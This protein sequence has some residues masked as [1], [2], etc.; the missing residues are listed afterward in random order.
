MVKDR[1]R[2]GKHQPLLVFYV[3][4]DG[5]TIKANKAP[6]KT[7]IMS[8]EELIASRNNNEKEQQRRLDKKASKRKGK[9]KDRDDEDR[10][11]PGR[12]KSLKNFVSSAFK[13]DRSSKEAASGSS[14][15]KSRQRSNG[16]HVLS[17]NGH[18]SSMGVI[19]P[20]L[21]INGYVT[22]NRS[23]EVEN[24]T[25]K[26]PVNSKERAQSQTSPLSKDDES[27]FRY[28][29]P[30]K[31][32]GRSSEAHRLQKHQAHL[33]SLETSIDNYES[34]E[35]IL[36]S[37]R[38]RHRRSKSQQL[39]VEH[40]DREKESS[41]FIAVPKNTV[42]DGR[43]QTSGKIHEQEHTSKHQAQRRYIDNGGKWIIVCV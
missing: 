6:R 28:D 27:V 11:P 32:D 9:K 4:Q 42:E 21:E 37:K 3:N 43:R 25:R 7:E 38:Q 30:K 12:R 5:E 10:N 17:V 35:D 24:E 8:K 26:S 41:R 33:K 39:P 22:E 14:S 31:V 16:D 13:K 2:R 15:S 34:E 36:D 29:S 23:V 18:D 1:C 20:Y 19:G 40:V